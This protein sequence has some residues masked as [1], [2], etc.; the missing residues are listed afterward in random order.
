VPEATA[1][2]AWGEQLARWAIPDEVLARAPESPYFFDVGEFAS[3]AD[4]AVARKGRSVSDSMALQALSLGGSVLDV[5]SGAG[6]ASLPLAGRAGLLLAVDERA[7][8]LAAFAARAEAI[9]VPFRGFEGRWPDVAGDVPVAEV[10]VSHHVAYNVADLSSFA[11]ALGS[12]ARRRVVLELT[13]AHPLAWTSPYWRA[14]HV[15]EVRWR[16]P[17]APL[18]AA[19][20]ERL[21]RRLCLGPDRHAELAALLRKAPPP[22]WRDLSTIWWDVQGA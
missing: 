15:R 5:G 11:L 7:E 8:L 17:R 20:F 13:A 6:A 16:Q 22:R 10:A 12:H 3:R 18:D 19:A 2:S 14:L 9:E 1:A 4:G 21:A